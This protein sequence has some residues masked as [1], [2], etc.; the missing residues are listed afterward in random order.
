VLRIKKS[1]WRAIILLIFVFQI[2]ALWC[3]DISTSA[4]L[5]KSTAPEGQVYLTNGFVMQDPSVMYHLCLYWL[6][7]SSFLLTLITF[8]LMDGEEEKHQ[9]TP[10]RPL[11]TK[12]SLLSCPVLNQKEKQDH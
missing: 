8:H 2:L 10:S 12:S 6:I 4:M 9:S 7:I 1:D 11:A 3:I 5:M